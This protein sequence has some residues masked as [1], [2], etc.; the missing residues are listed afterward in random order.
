MSIL[1]TDGIS[2]KKRRIAPGQCGDRGHAAYLP[3]EW[4]TLPSRPARIWLSLLAQL[5]LATVQLVLQALWQELWHSPQPPWAR[6]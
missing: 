1:L 2:S 4:F 5:W 6:D 3:K